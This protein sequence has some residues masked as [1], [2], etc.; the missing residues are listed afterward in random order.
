MV[1]FKKYFVM[2]HLHEVTVNSDISICTAPPHPAFSLRAFLGRTVKSTSVLMTANLRKTELQSITLSFC[3]FSIKETLI[4]SPV[5][6]ITMNKRVNNSSF[7][8]S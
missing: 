1:D 5:T 6:Q 8:S 7:L 2:I 4:N 3:I